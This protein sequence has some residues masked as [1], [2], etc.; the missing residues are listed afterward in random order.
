MH[1]RA[2]ARR[3]LERLPVRIDAVGLVLDDADDTVGAERFHAALVRAHD[4]VDE[5]FV[6]VTGPRTGHE[7]RLQRA[8]RDVGLTGWQQVADRVPLEERSV[9][10]VPT[11]V[12]ALAVQ[13][14]H[15]SVGAPNQRPNERIGVLPEIRH[16]SYIG[17]FVPLVN[18]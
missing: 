10:T 5:Q 18:M 14:E 1:D 11:Q 2:E 13:Q 15:Q 6:L 17:Q 7:G 9:H 3:A 8:H 16:T 4:P 12:T